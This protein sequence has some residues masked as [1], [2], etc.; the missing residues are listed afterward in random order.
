MQSRSQPHSQAR[1]TKPTG[2]REWEREKDKEKEKEKDKERE[3]DKPK[4][5][6]RTAHNDIERKYRTNLKD[7]IAELRD[8]VPALRTIPE[9]PIDDELL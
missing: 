2:D 7:R 5:G 4:A 3:K 8:A 9:D 6:D 1:P